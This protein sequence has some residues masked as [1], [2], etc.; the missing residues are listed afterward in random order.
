MCFFGQKNQEKEIQNTQKLINKF[1]A[2]AS[3]A[4]MA[5]E[6]KKVYNLSS[7]SLY[8]KKGKGFEIKELPFMAQ[9]LVLVLSN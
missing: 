6:V 5:Q 3:K 4:S 2:K 8:N 1:R 9:V 7:V